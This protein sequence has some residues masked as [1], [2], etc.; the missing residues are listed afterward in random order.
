[1]NSATSS[2]DALAWYTS[3]SSAILYD[4][5]FS[6]ISLYIC[7]PHTQNSSASAKQVVLTNI[8]GLYTFGIMEFKAFQGRFQSYFR[9]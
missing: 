4:A 1:M 5:V 8:H 6:M 7:A 2:S 9:Q 3:C